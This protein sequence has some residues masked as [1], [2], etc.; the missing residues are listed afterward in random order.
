M[1]F[2]LKSVPFELVTLL[3]DDEETPISMIGKK[4]LP[5]LQQQEGQY[6]PES[7]DI[8]AYVDSLGEY[9]APIVHPSHNSSQLNEWLT[10]VRS[11]HYPLAMPRWPLM[12]LEEFN[13]ESARQYFTGKKEKSIG[14]FAEAFKK[15]PQLIERAHEHL[16]ELE[17]LIVGE[18]YFWGSDLTIDDFHVFSSLRCLTTTKGV[19]FPSKLDNYMNFMSEATAVPLHWPDAIGAD[20]G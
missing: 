10:E 20:H 13:T 7:L 19:S 14:P 16:K 15:T 2:G 1:I 11:Y 6:L 4:M 12:P 5:I 3:N 8:V 17:D 18:P 9:G